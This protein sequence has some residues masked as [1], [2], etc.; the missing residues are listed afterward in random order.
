MFNA[1]HSL[2]F[3]F[4]IHNNSSCV[5]TMHLSIEWNYLI[6][7]QYCSKSIYNSYNNR[8]R[9]ENWN[10]GTYLYVRVCVCAACAWRHCH[11][12]GRPKTCAAL[13]TNS[14][15]ALIFFLRAKRKTV[16]CRIQLRDGTRS[17]AVLMY[18]HIYCTHNRR[19]IQISIPTIKTNIKLC[20][21]KSWLGERNVC[22]KCAI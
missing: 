19:E 4:R 20:K 6:V 22:R 14:I 10:N 7:L 3:K 18:L 5:Y 15:N 2:L 12:S 17:F 11:R 8:L 13:I 16:F 9:I 1:S 21:S